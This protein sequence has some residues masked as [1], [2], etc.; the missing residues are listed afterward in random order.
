MK[1]VDFLKKK[2]KVYIA[3]KRL[4]RL[5]KK[6]EEEIE[7]LRLEEERRIRKEREDILRLI[8]K[9][10]RVELEKQRKNKELIEQLK[11]AEKQYRKEQEGK[12]I[13]AF[14]GNVGPC[15]E[16]QSLTERILLKA[17]NQQ[18]LYP[19]EQY[20]IG[21]MKVDFA[22]PE[23]DL[24]IEVDGPQHEEERQ[25]LIDIRRSYVLRANGWSISR[26]KTDEVW[27]NPIKVAGKI[28]W[29][30]EKRRKERRGE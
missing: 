26:Y 30:I 9:E 27:N 21:L 5:V 2:I 17:L 12:R 20:E 3:K 4:E 7:R 6:R 13:R 24:V 11:E 14:L 19:E 25:H 1:I 22:F 18:D 16:C 23:E 28:K 15:K 29:I 10:E 8:E